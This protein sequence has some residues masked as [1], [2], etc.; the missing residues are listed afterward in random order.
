MEVVPDGVQIE[1]ILH[2]NFLYVKA[3]DLVPFDMWQGMVPFSYLLEGG[4]TCPDLRYDITC[5]ME[6]LAIDLS[7]NDE[8]EIKSVLSFNSFLRRPVKT[9][10]ITALAFQPFDEVRMGKRPGITGYIVKKGDDLWSLAKRYY[11]TKE[12]I[13][14]INEMTSETL[15]EGQ[16]ILIFKENMS[17]L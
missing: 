9:D 5:R 8:V 1:G 12:G 14:E 17:I 15:K 3:N 13:M 11:T 16:K 4:K 7:G 6:Q 10:V 2:V